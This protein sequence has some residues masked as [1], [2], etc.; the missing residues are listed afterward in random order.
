MIRL[1]DA[2]KRK[3]LNDAT[4]G[5]TMFHIGRLSSSPSI[6]Y[7]SRDKYGVI[8]APQ[9]VIRLIAIGSGDDYGLLSDLE[10]SLDD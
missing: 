9:S 2:E 10:G 7:F 4:E 8:V 6:S 3:I 5:E 1:T